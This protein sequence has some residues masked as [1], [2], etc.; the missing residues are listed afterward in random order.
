MATPIL[1]ALI[2]TK[3]GDRTALEKKV[4]DGDG[5]KVELSEVL[6]ELGTLGEIQSIHDA[7]LARANTIV[8]GSKAAVVPLQ[9]S[10]PYT[11]AAAAI[12]A[13]LTARTLDDGGMTGVVGKPLPPAGKTY[14]DYVGALSKADTS[15]AVADE[16]AKRIALVARRGMIDVRISALTV[17]AGGVEARFAQ[18]KAFLTSATLAAQSNSVAAAWWALFHVKAL[19]TGVVAADATTL[20]TAVDTACDDYATAYDDWV[21]ARDLLDK[22]LADRAAA[23]ADLAKADAQTLAAL[24]TFVG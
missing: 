2:S 4:T 7:A 10:A 13:G 23:D 1:T 18:A 12:A 15:L 16:A 24:A 5:A 9:S 21:K 3:T 8:T 19:L 17:Y 20:A 6:D 11:S 14:A 22:T